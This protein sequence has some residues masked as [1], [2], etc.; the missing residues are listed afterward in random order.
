[1][2]SGQKSFVMQKN[3][4]GIILTPWRTSLFLKLGKHSLKY[5]FC[6]VSY[7]SYAGLSSHKAEIPN[8]GY[9]TCL[10]GPK[11]SSAFVSQKQRFLGV[12]CFSEGSTQDEATGLEHHQCQDFDPVQGRHFCWLLYIA[13]AGLSLHHKGEIVHNLE[14]TFCLHRL[15]F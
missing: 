5:P 13:Y 14:D 10:C 6:G 7:I 2:S 1:M 8:T 4:F 11:T 3:I 9:N 12:T 15:W